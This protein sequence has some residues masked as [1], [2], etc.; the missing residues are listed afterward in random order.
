MAVWAEEEAKTQHV[1]QLIA[2]IP[3]RKPTF[4]GW[5]E[6]GWGFGILVARVHPPSV[7]MFVQCITTDKLLPICKMADVIL[8]A[9]GE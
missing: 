7:V 1:Q 6:V 8:E 2:Q 3:D 5:S 4:W 9:R